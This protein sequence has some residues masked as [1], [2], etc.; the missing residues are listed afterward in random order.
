M[1]GDQP[2]PDAQRQGRSRAS[3]AARS[4]TTTPASRSTTRSS[5]SRSRRSRQDVIW[6]G[7]RRRPRPG[8]ARRREELAE[9]DAEGDPRVD[10]DQLARR[11]AARQGR[12]ATSPRRCTSS[13]TSGPT[14]TRRPTTARPGRRSSGGIPENAFTR[15]IRE[16]PERHGLLYAGTETRPLRLLRRR[17]EL[18]ALPARTCPIVPITDLT[19][20][21]G[22]LVVAT[23]GRSFWILDD[24][25]SAA[26]IRGCARGG[27]GPRLF[28]PRPPCGFRAAG[29]VTATRRAGGGA[30]GKNPPN[31]VLVSYYLK[32]KP[33]EKDVP[34]RRV[35]GRRQR[36]CAR[37]RARRRR[38]REK[39]AGR[40][41]RA[42]AAS[43]TT[44]ATS[45]SS[46]RPGLNRLVWDMR[47]LKP[48][49]L[50][51]A[52]IWGNSQGPKVAPGTYTGPS[53]VRA[54]R[55]LH[56]VLRGAPASGTPARRP[57][58]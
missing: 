41:P 25:T 49:L 52:I 36:C 23:Q 8:D 37:S 13:T 19:V 57:R 15:V 3:P 34:D 16:D 29:S 40:R 20:K 6:V 21:N 35:P 24:L 53:E 46:R 27:E 26:R 58:T 51:K 11:F 39:E 12:R 2:R 44:R 5:R 54:A 32:E 45:R 43:G 7:H 14:S 30:L 9:R 38:R 22:D 1:G 47:I 42:A 18:A 28:K 56:G 48:S 10:P 33:G 55:R 50:P 4:R 31:G 17:R